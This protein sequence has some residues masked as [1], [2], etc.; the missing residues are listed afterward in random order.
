MKISLIVPMRNEEGCI[1]YVLKEVPRNIIHEIIL[2][3]GHSTDGT[4]TEAKKYIDKKK[5]KLLIQ[6]G[7]GYGDAFLEAFAIVKGDGII[8]MDADGSH[9]P[10]DIPAI[11]E[12]LKQG[13]EFVIASRY[14]PGGRSYDDTMIRWIGN[15]VFTLLINMVH[16]TR[17]ADSLYLF[18]GITKEG[19]Q[20]LHLTSKGFEF[21]VEILVKAHKAGLRFCEVPVVERKRISGDSKVNALWHGMKI[22]RMI[23]HRY[24]D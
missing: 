22:L 21:C 5:D 7:K 18:T 24:H 2:V 6:K 13:Y 12:K 23:F 16:G 15:R 8:M 11:V 3:D 4:I 9:N 17:V 1:G 19:L 10:Q 20:K 14:A